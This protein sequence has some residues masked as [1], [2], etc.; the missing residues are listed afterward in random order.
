MIPTMSAADRLRALAAEL[1]QRERWSRDQLLSYQQE[2]VCALLAHAAEHSPYYRETLGAGGLD[3][4]PTL[5]KQTL[6]EQWDRIVCEPRLRRALVESHAAGD[7]ADRP[8]LGDYE[9]FSTSGSSGLG[10]VF[11]FQPP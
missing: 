9:V 11:F 1:L 6:V 2:R 10:G 7:D 4:Q 8:L 5:T 3:A